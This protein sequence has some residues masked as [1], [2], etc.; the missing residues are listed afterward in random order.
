VNPGASALG[1][2]KAAINIKRGMIMHNSTSKNST[3]FAQGLLP[4]LLV[5]LFFLIDAAS[6]LTAAAGNSGNPGVFPPQSVPYG[7]S[8]GEWAAAWW[9]WAYSIPA[10]QNPITDQTGE[11]SGI[12]LHGSVFFLAGNY[13]GTTVRECTVPSGK[14][15][16]FPLL[17]QSWVQFPTDPPYT[18]DELRAI[19]APFVDNPTL[20]CELDGR[21]LQNLDSYRE[22]STVFSVTVPLGNLLG[23]DPG[24]YAPCVDDGYYLMLDPLSRGTHILHFTAD[25]AD[26]GFS[27]DVTYRLTVK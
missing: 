23:L 9:Q 12:G 14:G 18:I 5:S 25:T 1:S 26:H 24:T 22:Q 3:S 21:V 6:N 2:R 16:L 7:K 8:Y 15:I 27:L 11:F 20:T 10:A 19:I 17:N 4:L 13:G